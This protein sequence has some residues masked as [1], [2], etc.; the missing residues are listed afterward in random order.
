[1]NNVDEAIERIIS[2]WL[3]M[4]TH[5]LDNDNIK[6]KKAIETLISAYQEEKEKREKAEKELSYIEN[7]NRELLYRIDGVSEECRTLEE[8]NEDL[9]DEIFYL[10]R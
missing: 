1:M 7:Q 3:F 2:N 10:R 5:E 4:T 8:E 6:F 9:K